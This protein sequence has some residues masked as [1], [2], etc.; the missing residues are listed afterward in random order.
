MITHVFF[1]LANTEVC[2]VPSFQRQE[3]EQSNEQ[4]MLYQQ[5][6]RK[7]RLAGWL[8]VR[9]A[10]PRDLTGN[11]FEH[12]ERVRRSLVCTFRINSFSSL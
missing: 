2:T 4:A 1:P 11:G 12:L 5:L 3:N 10:H 8:L 9:E 6:W 7:S